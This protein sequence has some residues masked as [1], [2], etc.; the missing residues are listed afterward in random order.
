MDLLFAS[1]SLPLTTAPASPSWMPLA[2]A[3]S[4]LGSTVPG[5]AYR[6]G[7]L[8][9][10]VDPDTINEL[11]PDILLIQGLS[12]A[13]YSSKQ[14]LLDAWDCDTLAHLHSS[15]CMMRLTPLLM[16]PMMTPLIANVH[17]MRSV[18]VSYLHAAG[19]KV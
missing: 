6:I 11:R 12:P 17:S 7:W 9:P 14:Q 19:C 4:P 3:T 18:F 16:Y 1:S 8:L 2:S 5:H 15:T 10:N 13:S